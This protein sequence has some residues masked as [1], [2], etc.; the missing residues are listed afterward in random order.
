MRDKIIN[1]AVVGCVFYFG[2]NWVAD[3][4]GQMKKFRKQ[5]NHH[6]DGAIK[7]AS[8]LLE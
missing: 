8:K 3:N 7:Q 4:P 1:F 2:I 5:M 6:V